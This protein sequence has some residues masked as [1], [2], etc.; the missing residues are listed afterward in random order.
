LLT[1]LKQMKEVRI[2]ELVTLVDASLRRG[3]FISFDYVKANEERGRYV[4]GSIPLDSREFKCEPKPLYSEEKELF[5][6]W[7]V[8]RRAFRSFKA[9]SLVTATIEGQVFVPIFD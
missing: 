6:V 3:R 5:T 7:C 2:A 8:T 9:R 1:Y 4:H